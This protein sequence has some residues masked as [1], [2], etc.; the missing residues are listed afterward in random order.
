MTLPR[1]LKSTPQHLTSVQ[2]PTCELLSI[3]SANRGPSPDSAVF[4]PHEDPGENLIATI[5]GETHYEWLTSDIHLQKTLSH[6]SWG[7]SMP[8]SN[9]ELPMPLLIPSVTPKW[10]FVHQL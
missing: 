2:R 10:L 7:P 8:S 9:P 4:S 5:T 1:G 6:Q 3:Q